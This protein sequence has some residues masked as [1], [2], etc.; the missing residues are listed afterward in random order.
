MEEEFLSSNIV[1]PFEEPTAVPDVP[2]PSN[3]KYVDIFA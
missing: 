1:K 2:S 3:K